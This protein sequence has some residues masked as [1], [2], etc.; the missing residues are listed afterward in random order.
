VHDPRKNVRSD[1]QRVLQ[2]N[3]NMQRSQKNLST[4]NNEVIGDKSGSINQ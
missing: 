3:E 1:I 2:Q 4:C